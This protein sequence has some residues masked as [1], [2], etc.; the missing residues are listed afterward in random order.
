[1]RYRGPPGARH[2]DRRAI[3]GQDPEDGPC[4]PHHQGVGFSHDPGPAA[5]NLQDRSTVNLAG[6]SQVT[7]REPQRLCR[8]AAILLYPIG[9]I[10]AARAQVQG[11]EGGL[12]Y[13]APSGGEADEPPAPRR[14]RIVKQID[15]I[16]GDPL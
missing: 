12:A 2:N 14:L 16:R 3:G 5:R 9:Q 1:V 8:S 4:L 11:V 7:R 6:K 15:P 10:T 13:T